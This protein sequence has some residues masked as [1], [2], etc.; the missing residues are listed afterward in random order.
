MSIYPDKPWSDGQ[1]FTTTND[2]GET[3]FGV[4]SS[5][6]NAWSFVRVQSNQATDITNL[7]TMISEAP[8]FNTLKSQILKLL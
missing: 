2:N 8:D 5:S 4:Y 3:I 7:I 1:Q 6:S